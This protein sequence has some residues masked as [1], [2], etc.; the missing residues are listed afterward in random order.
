MG[1]ITGLG[2][3]KK[4]GVKRLILNEKLKSFRTRDVPIN[5]YS[6]DISFEV[7]FETVDETTNIKQTNVQH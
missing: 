2:T 7:Y 5:Y 1:I 4:W 6:F 3:E